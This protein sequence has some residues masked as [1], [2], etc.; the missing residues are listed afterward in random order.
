MIEF[1]SIINRR[2]TTA[3][4]LHYYLERVANMSTKDTKKCNKC[5]LV[6]VITEFK[7]QKNVNRYT[8]I[9]KDCD[10]L[11]NK[12]YYQ[13]HKSECIERSNR[14]YKEKRESILLKDKDRYQKNREKILEYHKEYRKN[15]HE[16]LSRNDKKYREDNPESTKRRNKEYYE[17]N[18]PEILRKQKI[19]AESRKGHI[20]ERTR[21]WRDRNM[22]TI[23]DKNNLYRA[24]PEN[25]IVHNIRERI[26]LG[27]KNGFG[28]KVCST[29]E[30]LGCDWDTVRKHLESLFQEGMTWE[31]HGMFGWHI[32]HIRPCASFDLS[33]P[34]QQK[35]CFHYTNLQPL[36]AEDNLRKSDKW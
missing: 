33:D 24:I 13:E 22:P 21:L 9:C 18:K 12:Q 4:L 6:K 20:A 27:I 26:R 8:T 34:E 31:N 15:N 11:R 19:Y 3:V 16:R 35:Q 10:R 7:F 5:G 1:R 28:K 29:R 30:L 14:R 2:V 23:R 17:K 36:W 25:R 32:D